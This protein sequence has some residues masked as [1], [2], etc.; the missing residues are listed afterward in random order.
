MFNVINSLS[1]VSTVSNDDTR[2]TQQITSKAMLAALLMNN[3][4]GMLSIEDVAEK[5]PVVIK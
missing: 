3:K 2:I 4:P 1:A 5:Y